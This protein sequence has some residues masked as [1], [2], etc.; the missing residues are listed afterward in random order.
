LAHPT[1]LLSTE[2]C[3]ALGYQALD[4]PEDYDLL[5]RA[6]SDGHRL[7]VVPR[8]LLH[9]RDH[10]RR[11]SRVDQRYRQ[12]RFVW[13]KAR[14]LSSS[15]LKDHPR[16]VLWGYG[17]TGRA[18]SRELSRF[19]HQPS[20]IV[21]VHPGRLGQTIAG[22]PVIPATALMG[23]RGRP[24]IVSVAGATARCEIRAALERMGFREGA[25]YVCAA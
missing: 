3:R 6:L 7:G 23:L 1:W 15:F 18:L 8:R 17:D 22:A 24:L 9:W 20:H 13:L 5:L 2:L 10:E 16:Y 14:S 11:L 21:E 25:D 12:T 4:A 19:G